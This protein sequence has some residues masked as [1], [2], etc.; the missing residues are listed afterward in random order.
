MKINLL[1]LCFALFY[2]SNALGQ[3]E[4]RL[5][6][7]DSYGDSDNEG[8]FTILKSTTFSYFPSGK[9][10]EEVVDYYEDGIFDQR[11][12][13]FF[14]YNEDESLL[15]RKTN[16]RY[17]PSVDLW[18]TVYWNDFTY[19]ANGCEIKQETTFNVGG[20]APSKIEYQRDSDCKII[21]R[22][23]WLS[24]G[25]VDT[26][27]DLGVTEFDYFADGI[28]YEE[29]K[30]R[31]YYGDSTLN[32]RDTY[33]YNVDGL[34]EEE[35]KITFDF[36]NV[37]S[38]RKRNYVYDQYGNVDTEWL[39]ISDFANPDWYLANKIVYQNEYDDQF[40]ITNS[41]GEVNVP[42]GS[43]GWTINEN[44]TTIKN[45][46]YEC[47]DLLAQE[48]SAPEQIGIG[49]GFRFIYHYKGED[50]CFDIENTTLEISVNPNP[51]FGNLTINSPVFQSGNTMISVY[52]IS[53]KLLLGKTEIS[54]M[55]KIELDLS[56]LPNGMYVV[57]LMN[58]NH[59]VQEKVVVTK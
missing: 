48:T 15:L 47:E 27:A 10:K 56:H 3:M 51:T 29:R 28:S 45:Y 4:P 7:K 46:E 8:D 35:E 33:R 36:I 59:F 37:W 14:E 55:E 16:R 5:S 32:N 2:M 6:Q 23:N 26:L 9:I 30:F 49:T 25:T 43:G 17:N 22:T 40:R 18:V 54:R 21:K 41:K 34:L 13:G 24:G 19:D 11:R 12:G 58:Q 44:T 52:D 39:Y 20:G 1:F 42:D 38:G 50:D 31:V 57:Q 53:G